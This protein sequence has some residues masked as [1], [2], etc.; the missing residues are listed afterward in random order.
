MNV[1]FKDRSLWKTGKE[2]AVRCTRTLA[3]GISFDDVF[4][5]YT[6][7]VRRVVPSAVEHPI[8]VL[9][10]FFLFHFY[11]AYVIVFS[12]SL[13]V[14]KHFKTKGSGIAPI[15]GALREKAGLWLTYFF[16]LQSVSKMTIGMPALD[17]VMG[18]AFQVKPAINFKPQI[19]IGKSKSNE[20]VISVKSKMNTTMHVGFESDDEG[21]RKSMKKLKNVKR[22]VEFATEMA[23][24]LVGQESSGGE[25]DWI[26]AGS[27]S[28]LLQEPEL[29]ATSAVQKWLEGTDSSSDDIKR[30]LIKLVAEN[31][32]LRRKSFMHRTEEGSDA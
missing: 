6:G 28:L 14:F 22:G 24:A 16:V 29:E 5:V 31:E 1:Q 21:T 4:S 8:D 26:D 25:E 10:A 20:S 23:E 2:V 30:H 17:K 11:L 12:V 32:H 3:N 13:A 18:W 27:S 7:Y 19:K 9:V 15:G